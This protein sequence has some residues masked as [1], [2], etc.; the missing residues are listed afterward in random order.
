MAEHCSSTPAVRSW[1]SLSGQ[2]LRQ[3]LTS[4]GLVFDTEEK[5]IICVKCQYAVKPS[6]AV[7]KHLGDKQEISAKARH[8]LDVFVK[9][10]QLP[11]P[12]KLEPQA[13]GCARHSNLATKSGV[14]YGQCNCRSTSLDL[15][16]RRLTKTH[17]EKSGRKTWLRDYLRKDSAN[18][19]ERAY[20]ELSSRA[21]LDPVDGLMAGEGWNYKSVH[22]YLEEEDRLLSQLMLILYLC[23]GQAPQSTELPIIEHCNEPTTSRGL[24]AHR[25]AI[26]FVTRHSKARHSTNQEFQVAR[27]LPRRESNLVLK[28]LVY[29]RPFVDMLNR[30]CFGNKKSGPSS[31][32][33]LMTQSGLERL[34]C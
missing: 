25:G 19:L 10:L 31:S 26:C 17:G 3:R 28:Y 27:Y 16:Q 30:K 11:D 14:V 22:R 32:A 8:G 29:I 13:D 20:F 1:K 15:T 18:N 33:R 24:Y 34:M 2:E 9:Q 7:S 5:G 21:C 23:G 4:L 12:N 6:D